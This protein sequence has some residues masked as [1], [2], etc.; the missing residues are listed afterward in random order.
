MKEKLKKIL[1]D[2]EARKAGLLETSKTSQDAVE[3]RSINAELEVLNGQITEMR[4]AIAECPDEPATPP[5]NPA[6]PH[7][8]E[9][10]SAE[11]LAAAEARAKG[12]GQ[13]NPIAAY[14]I[15]TGAELQDS[16][17]AREK[18]LQTKY[19]QRG[20]DLK[21]G[22]AAVYG[23]NEIP[24]SRSI[25]IDTAGLVIPNQYS[26]KLNPTFN[27]VSSIVDLVHAISMP[28]GETYTQGF[29]KPAS[30]AAAYTADGTDYHDTDPVYDYV[31]IAKT[32]LTAYTEISKQASKLPN[33]NYQSM[34]SAGV[35]KSLRKKLARE[36]MIGD[37]AAGHFTGI[38]N[39]PANVIPVA[40]DLE[41]S[42]IDADT[43]DKIVF[44][45]GGD[46]DVEAAA[47]LI[48]NKKDL[49]AFAAIRAT[50]GKKLYKIVTNG[51]VGTISSDGSFSVNYVLNSTCPA[52]SLAATAASTYCMAYGVLDYYEMPVFSD[53]SIE[54][55]TDYKFKQ[56]MTAYAG[57]TY[58][59]GNVA[60]YKGFVRIKKAA[61]V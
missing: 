16:P 12:A 33:V 21:A 20:A 55:S 57:E 4:S 51:N 26:D 58:A 47:Y 1:G 54:M 59:G 61:V 27:E 10:R 60:A 46:E 29:E 32:A 13:F 37:G 5:V 19:E 28:N 14:G 43:L 35:R 41:F 34:C 24:I 17:E 3:L 52:L 50:D 53:I 11:V 36:I 44:G 48:L 18:A 31:T 38:F 23:L 56:G 42:K 22:K 9:K 45:Y 7:A 30:E 40:S 8:A 39:A 15:G 49:A 2:L 25:T 6:D